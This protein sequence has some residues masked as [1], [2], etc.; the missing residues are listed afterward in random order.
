MSHDI[1]ISGFRCPRFA[2]VRRLGLADISAAAAVTGRCAEIV[3]TAD[4]ARRLA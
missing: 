3:G 4:D 2:R 1:M